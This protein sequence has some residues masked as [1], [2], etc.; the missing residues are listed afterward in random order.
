MLHYI[1]GISGR[2]DHVHCGFPDRSRPSCP[3][4]GEDAGIEV[5]DVQA[6][7]GGVEGCGEG[8]DGAEVEEVDLVRLERYARRI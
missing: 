3:A 6:G 1:A 2:F 8:K 7:K 4:E 5:E